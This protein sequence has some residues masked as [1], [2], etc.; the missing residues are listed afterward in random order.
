MVD[1]PATSHDNAAWVPR[2]VENVH[3]CNARR[4]LGSGEW[5]VAF[6]SSQ[7]CL[8]DIQTTDH[9]CPRLPRSL[10]ARRV[11]AKTV[12]ETAVSARGLGSMNHWQS[13]RQ[14]PATYATRDFPYMYRA[15]PRSQMSADLGR[16]KRGEVSL[17]SCRESQSGQGVSQDPS[18]DRT[19]SR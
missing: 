6:L 7:H 2:Q 11:R 12:S 19:P 14:R 13:V 5:P 8:R 1:E 17:S 4:I 15:T 9:Q 10:Q 3:R 16:G 18:S